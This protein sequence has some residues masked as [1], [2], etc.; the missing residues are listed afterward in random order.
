MISG[1]LSVLHEGRR[2]RIK[3]ADLTRNAYERDKA[4]LQEQHSSSRPRT[5]AADIAWSRDNP[6]LVDDEGNYNGVD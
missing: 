5:T 6:P 3:P 4:P 1:E 2:V